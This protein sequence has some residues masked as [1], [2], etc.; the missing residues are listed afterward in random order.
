MSVHTWY[1][2]SVWLHIVAAAAWVGGMLFLGLVLIPIALREKYRALAPTLLHELALR[3]RSFG[4]LTL[5]ILIL[6]GVANL[7]LR[8]FTWG[9]LA[10]AGFWASGFGAIL[11]IKLILVA[12]LL[13]L[14]ALHDFWIGPR[15]TTLWQS[16]P[17]APQLARLRRLSSWMGRINLL[18]SLAIVALAVILVRG[19][20]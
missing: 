8:G 16:H 9:M 14:G 18:L 17:Q 10:T 11:K 3:F 1:L 15:T 5:A 4:W 7:R 2:I 19:A 20:G 6:T 12:V 13:V